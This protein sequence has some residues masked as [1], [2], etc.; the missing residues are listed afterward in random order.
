MSQDKYTET[1]RRLRLRFFLAAA[2]GFIGII[3]NV[4]FVIKPKAPLLYLLWWYCAESI[5][6]LLLMAWVFWFQCPHCGRIFSFSAK[7]LSLY[8]C[9]HCGIPIG[10]ERDRPPAKLEA[11]LWLSLRAQRSNLGV[12]GPG[13]RDC[14]VA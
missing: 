10:A 13:Q 14:F 2:I 6:T 9:V 4:A 1:W 8:R 5:L 11:I 7:R 3:F 12:V